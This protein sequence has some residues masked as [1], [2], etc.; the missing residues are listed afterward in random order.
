M[1]S[2]QKAC[3]KAAQAPAATMVQQA[4]SSATRIVS[5]SSGIGEKRPLFKVVLNSD[6]IKNL[7]AA[8]DEEIRKQEEAVKH[9]VQIQQSVTKK[10]RIAT[11]ARLQGNIGSITQANV[12]EQSPIVI[13]SAATSTTLNVNPVTQVTGEDDD[14]YEADDITEVEIDDEQLN[15]SSTG[16]SIKPVVRKRAPIFPFEAEDHYVP[17]NNSNNVINKLAINPPPSAAEKRQGFC[18]RQF[19]GNW[20]E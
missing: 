17:D 10:R 20:K 9:V 11:T 16:G 2:H 4:T 12:G 1:V 8:K 3:S 5:H 15:D 13:V 7:I 18:L 6:E 19:K 14:E